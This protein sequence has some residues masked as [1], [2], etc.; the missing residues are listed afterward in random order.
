[1]G[2]KDLRANIKMTT[3]F[4]KI[5]RTATATIQGTDVTQYDGACFVI[6]VGTHT[7]DDLEV[8]FQERD[9]AGSWTDIANA[10]LEGSD[11]DRAI[12]AGDADSEIYVGYLGNK[13]D[14]G[15][16]IT[17]TGTGDAVVGVH[18]IKGYP[19]QIPAN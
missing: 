19:K 2:K 15:A 14:I 13:E 1:M 17:D 8:K 16:V 12:V 6:A 4:T 11:N 7:A 18:V 10:D 5:Q 3:L 9:A